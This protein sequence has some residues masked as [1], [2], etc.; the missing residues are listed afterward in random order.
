MIV[1]ARRRLD[2]L[3][4][5]EALIGAEEVDGEGA[6]ENVEPTVSFFALQ[7]GQQPPP[8]GDFG[9]AG[10]S[11][12]SAREYYH[13]GD[14]FPRGTLPIAMLNNY[15]I[16]GSA[17]L[18]VGLKG[19]SRGQIFVLMVDSG[20]VGDTRLNSRIEKSPLPIAAGISGFA[21][22]AASKSCAA[23]MAPRV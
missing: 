7:N 13:D 6:G 19:K 18:L 10:H 16:D 8:T 14:S 5:P 12:E 3:N 9:W 20:S 15:G 17:W 11:V 23:V 2:V 21:R 4:R 1:R 22:Q